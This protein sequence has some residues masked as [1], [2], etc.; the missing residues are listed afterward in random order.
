TFKDVHVSGTP[1]TPTRF[2]GQP[3]DQPDASLPAPDAGPPAPD[4][5]PPGPVTELAVLQD[6]TAASWE[7]GVFPD[8]GDLNAEAA[9]DGTSS[10]VVYLEF[11]APPRAARR[12]ELRLHT[13]SNASAAGGSG[14]V[15]QVTAG[16]WSESTLTWAA[17]P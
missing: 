10:A 5:G 13:Q 8:P 7:P 16:G 6:V 17:R 12:A 11:P 1:G 3:P 14:R 15:C 4:A 2:C 9:A